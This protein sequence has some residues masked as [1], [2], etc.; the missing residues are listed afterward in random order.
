[1]PIPNFKGWMENRT[2]VIVWL[3]IFFPVGLY[4]VWMGNVFE[5]QMKWTITGIIVV[6]LVLLRASWLM[7]YLY[8]LILLP[9]G[10]Y[11]AWK[12]PGIS[13][14]AT[15][16][17]SGAAALILINFI[18]FT[19]QQAQ[20]AQQGGDIYVPGPTCEKV[21][22]YGSCTYYR[23]SDCNVIGQMCN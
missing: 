22:T 23:D 4:A 1:M 18:S 20:Q 17:F 9:A 5:K 14:T 21:Q 3:L 11:L 15:Y 6:V 19:M 2:L 8:L 16:L 10:L 7:D 13:K 12:D